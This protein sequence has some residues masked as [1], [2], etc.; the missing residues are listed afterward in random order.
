MNLTVE[1]DKRIVLIGLINLLIL[2]WLIMIYINGNDKAIFILII[3]PPTLSTLNYILAGILSFVN[4][5]GGFHHLCFK[6]TNMGD[7]IGELNAK[8]LITLVA[9]QPGE[10]FENENIAFMLSRFGI[11]IELIETNKKAKII[12]K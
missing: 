7:T 10:A 2:F 5:G 9:P 6:C 8:G 12:E 4:K 3:G 11:N 1:I